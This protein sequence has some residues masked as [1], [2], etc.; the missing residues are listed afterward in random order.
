MIQVD[1][2]HTIANELREFSGVTRVK[3]GLKRTGAT[4]TGSHQLSEAILEDSTL[5]ERS[6]IICPLDSYE[7]AGIKQERSS[8]LLFY[9]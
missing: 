3:W 6:S 5:C 2:G 1:Q 7:S 8:V 9:K 4:L